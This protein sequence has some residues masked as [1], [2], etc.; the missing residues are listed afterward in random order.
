[1]KNSK[2]LCEKKIIEIL[3]NLE[4]TILRR[5]SILRILRILLILRSLETPSS[6]IAISKWRYSGNFLDPLLIYEELSSKK[7]NPSGQA[8]A[9]NVGLGPGLDLVP[10]EEDILE[11][12]WAS[13]FYFIKATF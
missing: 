8:Q 2:I 10:F 7:A 4:I 11:P 6:S 5:I 3:R 13:N 12:L 1:M 9:L